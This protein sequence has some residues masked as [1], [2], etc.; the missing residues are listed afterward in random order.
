M[1]FAVKDDEQTT[2]KIERQIDRS[3]ACNRTREVKLQGERDAQI[4]IH[5]QCNSCR[6]TGAL[7]ANHIRLKEGAT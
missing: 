4:I 1:P 6:S 5:G 3:L 2:Q 7:A